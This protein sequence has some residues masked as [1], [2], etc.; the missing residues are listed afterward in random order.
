MN[1]ELTKEGADYI[2]SFITSRRLHKVYGELH[3]FSMQRK[4]IIVRVSVVQNFVRLFIKK[5]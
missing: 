5:E 2:E 4:R 1:I 3:G